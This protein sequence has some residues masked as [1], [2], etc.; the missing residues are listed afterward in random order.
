MK[1]FIIVLIAV[2]AVIFAIFY[3]STKP[4][5]TTAEGFLK[6]V[7]DNNLTKAESFL[8]TGFKKSINGAQLSNY[9]V[10]YDI[11][12][13]KDI[14][15]GLNRRINFKGNSATL[16]GTITD[17]NGQKA[18]IIFTFKKD[19]GQWKIAGIQKVLT[20]QEKERLI[21]K[22]KAI[23]AYTTLSRLTMH[24]LAVASKDNNFKILYNYISKKWQKEIS[25]EDL[26]KNYGVFYKN[27]INLLILDKIK[28][29]L[30][31]ININKKGILTLK[32]YYIVGKN[33]VLFDQKYIIEDKKWKLVAL[34]VEIH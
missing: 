18:P 22:A 3:F 25:V 23:K 20:K 14:D 9:L 33:R 31:T 11:Y 13:Y 7:N 4:L 27:K 10:T 1:K 24:I 32:G 17:K 15:F 30:T 26:Q 12:G 5:V 16:K 21:K 8:T 29:T 34:S 6:A 2:V 28:P 19:K